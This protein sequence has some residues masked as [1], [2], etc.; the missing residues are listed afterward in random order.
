MVPASRRGR[1][2]VAGGSRMTRAHE[3]P[4]DVAK[5]TVHL[6]DSMEQVGRISIV[7]GRVELARK[8]V[9]LRKQRRRRARSGDSAT[10]LPRA[11]RPTLRRRA[12]SE[13]AVEPLAAVLR[14][15]RIA[16]TLPA[17]RSQARGPVT[18]SHRFAAPNAVDPRSVS[19]VAASGQRE[20][21]DRPSRGASTPSTAI[22]TAASAHAIAVP[23][24]PALMLQILQVPRD[25]RAQG[26]GWSPLD[27]AA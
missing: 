9:E 19:R 23:R 25:A 21:R 3:A 7:A 24:I 15:T 27:R 8:V 5:S 26:A 1:R 16:S 13:L 22:R 11:V 17:S 18:G 14:G 4:R 10:M 20:P 6:S 2:S 12:A